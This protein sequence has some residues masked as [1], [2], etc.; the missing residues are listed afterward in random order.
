[1]S[2]NYCTA[3]PAGGI[4]ET[5]L[6][7]FWEQAHRDRDLY[8]ESCAPLEPLIVPTTIPLVRDARHVYLEL[9]GVTYQLHT[10]GHVLAAEQVAEVI[11]VPGAFQPEEV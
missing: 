10:T 6:R 1:M 2:Q 8:L 11:K 4:E 5:L 3:P 9:E 7:L